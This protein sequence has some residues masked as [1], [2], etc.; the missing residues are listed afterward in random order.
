MA[1]ICS[2]ILQIS[3]WGAQTSLAS[4]PALGVP[5]SFPS[6]TL[7]TSPF[8]QTILRGCSGHLLLI[9]LSALSTLR[10]GLLRDERDREILALRQ[11]ALIL[12]WRL[13][14]RP[15]LT[16]SERLALLF[17]HRPALFSDLLDT[18]NVGA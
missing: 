4:F 13:A 8:D 6:P 9:L 16:R 3:L 7:S 11:Q 15:P 18:T 12:Q 5:A 14:K 10:L 1:P 2:H 17:G